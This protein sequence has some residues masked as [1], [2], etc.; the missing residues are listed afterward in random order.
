MIE[1]VDTKNQL[2]NI[3]TKPLAKDI[4]FEL[5]RDFGILEVS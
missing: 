5:R 3:F 4:F 2:A 1:Y